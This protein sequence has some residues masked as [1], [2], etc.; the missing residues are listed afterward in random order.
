M[1]K[2]ALFIAGAAM[3]G[4][5]FA[6]TEWEIGGSAYRV[7]TLYHANVGPGMTETHLNMSLG[8]YIGKIYVAQID[9]QNEYNDIRVLTKDDMMIGHTSVY[10]LATYHDNDSVQQIMGVNADFFSMNNQK[11]PAAGY[12]ISDGSF[13]STG[14]YAADFSSYFYLENKRPNLSR[15]AAIS[16]TVIFPNS[17]SIPASLNKYG[18]SATDLIIFTPAYGDSTYTNDGGN[19]CT[20][21]L[22]SGTPTDILKDSQMEFE[23]TSNVVSPDGNKSLANTAIPRDGYVLS[24][25]L[26]VVKSLKVGDRIRFRGQLYASGLEI[27]PSQLVGGSPIM[28]KNGIVDSAR[29]DDAD[30]SLAHL[31]NLE[32]RTAVG[33]SQDRKQLYMVVVDGRDTGVSNGMRT[34]TL[35]HVMRYLGCWN[36]MNFDGGGSSQFYVKGLKGPNGCL[37]RNK[38]VGGTYLRPVSNGLFA[39]SRAPKDD[40]IT[41]IEIVDKSL[42][43]SEG[44]TYTPVVYGYNRYGVLVNTNVK[45]FTIATAPEIGT[46]D[47]NTLVV[48]KGKFNTTLTVWYEGLSYTI[49]VYT[50][51]GGTYVSEVIE[52]NSNVN[53]VVT[54]Y[55]TLQG[56]KITNPQ[57]GQIVIVRRGGSVA[58]EIIR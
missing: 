18:R 54:E 56:V 38:P 19:E 27:Y 26:S 28:L 7:D 6:Y 3:C 55:Y 40:V 35:G 11:V 22:V 17:S 47:N 30:K 57:K 48:G 14:S 16:A 5:A 31:N 49:P 4:T 29:V 45:G 8:S 13:I 2:L 23:I 58:K 41:S 10:N 21:K 53:D 12:S 50:N 33:Y 52:I 32:P 15:N 39:V 44:D 25:C 36:A 43:L 42:Y 9:L 20:M 51:G 1:K 24:S 37:V 34:K 46:L